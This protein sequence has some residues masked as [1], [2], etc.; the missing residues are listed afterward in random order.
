MRRRLFKNSQVI[1]GLSEIGQFLNKRKGNQNLAHAQKIEGPLKSREHSLSIN[2]KIII[3]L[4]TYCED[5]FY[6]LIE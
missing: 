1:E 2:L 4:I 3:P 5:L 6:A